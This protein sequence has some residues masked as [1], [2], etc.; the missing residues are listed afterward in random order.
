MEIVSWDHE[1]TVHRIENLPALKGSARGILRRGSSETCVADGPYPATTDNGNFI[2]DLFLSRPID[3]LSQASY[4]LSSTSGVVEHG[5]FCG[6]V[7][8]WY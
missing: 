5:L 3:D 8:Y 2:L 1:H 4:E 6:Q 7:S